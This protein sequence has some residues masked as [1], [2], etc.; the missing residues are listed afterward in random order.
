MESKDLLLKLELS[1]A[2]HHSK[3]CFKNKRLCRH[4]NEGVISFCLNNNYPN[5]TCHDDIKY[6][7]NVINIYLHRNSR[8]KLSLI[9]Y[10]KIER[11][12]QN[13][14]CHYTSKRY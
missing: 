9:I 1:A 2:G 5:V 8:L 13:N 6:I 4:G 11:I 3:M 12:S 10:L 7:C 14:M